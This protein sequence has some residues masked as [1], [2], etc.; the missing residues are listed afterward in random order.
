[1][2]WDSS[3]N[4]PWPSKQKLELKSSKT[5]LLPSRSG[6]LIEFKSGVLI[7]YSRAIQGL[8]L[9][10]SPRW[11]L[12]DFWMI[13][14]WFLDNFWM[15]SGWYLDDFWM[16][17]GWYLGNIWMMRSGVLIEFKIEVFTCNSRAIQGLKLDFSPS[18]GVVKHHHSSICHN[19]N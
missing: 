9:D 10:F 6:V 1:M 11:F 5:W 4:S 18:W 15:I 16:I 19:L 13:S 14:G 7:G 3:S 17:S 8:K 12:D 2:E